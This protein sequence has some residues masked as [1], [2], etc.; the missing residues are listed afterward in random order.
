MKHKTDLEHGQV[1]WNFFLEAPVK[2]FIFTDTR[3]YMQVHMWLLEFVH[4]WMGKPKFEY[5][6]K[7]QL[8]I[9]PLNHNK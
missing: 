9:L 1:N 5:I 8:Y 7:G 4:G 6:Q 2:F 3:R